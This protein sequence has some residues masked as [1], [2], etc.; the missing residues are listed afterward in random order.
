MGSTSTPIDS[1]VGSDETIVLPSSPLYLLPSDS[2]GTML[3]SSTFCGTSYGSWRRGMLLGLSC[4]NKLGIIRGTIPKPSPDS[5][6]FEP[7]TRCNNM[8]VA[9]ILNNLDREIRETVMYTE[10]AERLWNEIEKR[11]GQASSIKIYHIRKEIS[12]VSQ[13]TFSI[14]SYFN[15][16]KKLWDELSFSISYPDCVCGCK[17]KFQKLDEDQKIHQFLMGLNESYL[18]LGIICVYTM[19]L[20]DESQSTIQAVIPSFNSDSMAFSTGTQKPYNQRANFD[21]SKRNNLVCRYCKNP[22][23]SIEK[24]FKL[25]DFPPRFPAKFKRA[26]TF[27]QVS[28]TQS[29]SQP[30]RPVAIGSLQNGLYVLNPATLTSSCNSAFNT[31]FANKKGYKLLTLS[32]FSIF[33]FRDVIF[34][35]HIFPSSAPSSTRLFPPFVH[36]VSLSDSFPYLSP[37]PINATP[38]S[39]H[40]HVPSP[41][42]PLPSSS[43]LQPS[44]A[45]LSSPLP[46]FY[47]QAA[48]HPAWQEAMIKEFQALEANN[49]W[50]IVPLPVGK[51]AI[52][53][54]KRGWV[55][56]QLDVNNAFVHGDLDE[57]VFMKI[58]QGLS[59]SSFDSGF[60]PSLNDY[61]L[62]KKLLGDH[63][64]IV[65]VYVDDI[66]VAGDVMS[67]ITALKHF[68]DAQFKIKDLGEIHYFLGLEILKLPHGFLVGQHKFTTDIL[69]EYNCSSSSPVVSPLDPHV[70]LSTDSGDLLPDPSIYRQLVGKLNYLQHTRLDI[71]FNVQHLSQFMYA[72]RVPHLEVSLIS[73]WASCSDSRRSVSRFLLLL[74]GCPVSWKSKKQPTIALSFAE[75]EYRA[76]RMLVA[77]ITRLIHLLG[78]LGGDNLCPV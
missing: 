68:L 65:A 8:V 71:S 55:V 22:G 16:I 30:E 21:T 63:L 75:A 9:W 51:K 66:L 14:S 40:L 36:F 67:G 46:H 2:P 35:E 54:A 41:N 24:C 31:S 62:F 56:Y 74:G 7:W 57:E 58:P 53:A 17:E 32:N 76:L 70:K 44:P 34:H 20:N 4:K 23:H 29:Q 49:T 11:F 39:S 37:D 3:V 13:G 73:D 26:A 27:A 12:S 48:F 50:D 69:Q 78:E 5:P 61:S 38:D 19:L 52:P 25:H 15:R 43:H 6:L 47:H 60:Q 59:V 10:S 77:K 72:P 18:G 42:S 1:N 64:T 28:D 45:P 33:F